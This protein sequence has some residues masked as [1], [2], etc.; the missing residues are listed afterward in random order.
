M[1]RVSPGAVYQMEL[2]T[3]RPQGG[4]PELHNGSIRDLGRIPGLQ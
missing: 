3:G 4:R 2:E 1:D